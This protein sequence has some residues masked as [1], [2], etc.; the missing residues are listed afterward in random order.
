MLKLNE[1]EII[2]RQSHSFS[3]LCY[4]VVFL[5]LRLLVSRKRI[6]THH[7]DSLYKNHNR[8]E[9]GQIAKKLKLSN[10]FPWIY[11]SP[12]HKFAPQ[13]FW[14]SLHSLMLWITIIA[15]LYLECARVQTAFPIP[16]QRHEPELFWWW[17]E[18]PLQCLLGLSIFNK[19][20]LYFVYSEI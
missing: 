15:K 2:Q 5:W 20:L 11:I 9:C 7:L 16:L 6:I 14:H 19:N 8:I 1:K 10:L 4:F 12:L 18:V 3:L 17:C 13:L